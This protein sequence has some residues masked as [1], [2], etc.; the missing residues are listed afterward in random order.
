ICG[1]GQVGY[2]IAAYLAREDNDITIIDTNA[3]LIGQINN[4][5]DVNGIVGYAS[6]PD[7]L[8]QAGAD[9]A[10]MI[11]AVTHADEVN[12]IACQVAH[13]LFNVPKKVARVREQA[14]LDP[15]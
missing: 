3:R 6:H 15:A 8:A 4:E 10:D 5:L 11:I 14:Y 13:S 1:A 9:E 2:N 12:M 7:V